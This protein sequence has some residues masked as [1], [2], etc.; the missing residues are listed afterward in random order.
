MLQRALGHVDRLHRAADGRTLLERLRSQPRSRMGGLC[1]LYYQMVPDPPVPV[2]PPPPHH[3][4]PEVH[5]HLDGVT[6]R[7]T[8]AAALQQAAVSKLQQQLAGRLQVFTDGS[9]MPDGSAAAACVILSRAISRQCRLPFPASSTAAELAGLHLVA[10]LLAEDVPAQPVAVLCDS[11]AALQTL[12]NHRRAGLTGSLLATK[13][14]ALAAAGTSVSF[15]WL[16]SHVGIAGNEEADTLA[17]A[18]H[19]LGTPITQTVAVRDYSQARIKKL[20]AS[21]HPDQRVANGRGPRRLPEAGL[22]R[23]ER[24]NLLR[25]RTG[26]VWTAARRYL[27][28]CSAS[29]ACSRC[30]DP[31]TLEHLLC[32]CPALAQERSRVTA[33]YRRHGLPA[34]TLEHLLFPSRPHLPALRSLVEFLD[35]TGIVAYR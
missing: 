23:R 13:Y 9:V 21:V 17:K 1:A 11:K 27:K 22:T 2:A 33:A 32:A 16:P 35:E 20:L 12:A 10:D 29:P 15:H 19:Q 25:L 3:Q 4:P 14:R 34:T 24:A 8:P 5:L 31:E 28:G 18:A 26:C 7:R 30:G 6:K